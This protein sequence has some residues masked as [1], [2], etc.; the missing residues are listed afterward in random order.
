M[1]LRS[2]LL[3]TFLF[4]IIL[5]LWITGY[6]LEDELISETTEQNRVNILITQLQRENLILKEKILEAEALRNITQKAKEQGF[7]EVK[8]YSIIYLR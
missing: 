5:S 2:N 8:H 1:S 3:L 6:L 4:I 7:I